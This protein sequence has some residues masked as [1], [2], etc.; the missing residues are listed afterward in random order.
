MEKNSSII[1]ELEAEVESM[2]SPQAALPNPHL[3]KDFTPPHH[4]KTQSVGTF[5]TKPQ[6]QSEIKPVNHSKKSSLT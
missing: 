6:L 2:P 3:Y 1:R 5:S 4:I